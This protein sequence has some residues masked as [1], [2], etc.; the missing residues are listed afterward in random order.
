M[1]L[2]GDT[3][4]LRV[5][6]RT[7]SGNVV[8]PNDVTLRILD[9]NTYQEI[10]NITVSNND[11]V[12]IGIYECDYVIPNGDSETLVYEFSGTYDNKPILARGSFDRSFI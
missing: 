9:G 3:V 10:D 1:A 2:I 5:R 12:D 7:F 11:K 4:R 8:D 6:F